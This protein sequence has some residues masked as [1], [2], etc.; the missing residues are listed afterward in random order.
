MKHTRPCGGAK[1]A[2][3]SLMQHAIA[4]QNSPHVKRG[5]P[6]LQTGATQLSHSQIC[7]SLLV[8][9]EQRRANAA[10]QHY[11]YYYDTQPPP[12]HMRPTHMLPRRLTHT[13]AP[14][15]ASPSSSAAPQL[16]SAA[17]ITAPTL[18][19]LLPSG[20]ASH[21]HPP[22]GPL[23]DTTTKSALPACRLQLPPGASHLAVDLLQD[24][25]AVR[26]AA[27]ARH[28]G[29]YR[30]HQVLVQL[31]IADRQRA[32]HHIIAVAVLQEPRQQ[33]AG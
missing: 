14:A 16:R 11:T 31:P 27:Q 32:L 6:K 15:A 30:V 26:R 5:P 2:M 29:L 17:G 8:E 20:C 10:C 3:Q 25:L 28:K 19:P 7:S 12:Q 22:T 13:A 33:R 24:A 4:I 1:T 9:K 18:L 21:P 23:Q